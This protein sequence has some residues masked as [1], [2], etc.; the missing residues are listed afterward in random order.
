MALPA[1]R[2]GAARPAKLILRPGEGLAISIGRCRPLPAPRILGRSLLEAG[3]QAFPQG[4]AEHRKMSRRFFCLAIVLAAS[5]IV[6]TQVACAD[7]ALD[8]EQ[9]K[10][11]LHTATIEEDGFICKTVRMVNKGSLPADLFQST[12][13]WARKKPRRKFQYFKHAL[14]LRAAE[15]GIDLTKCQRST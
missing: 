3:G 9:I 1:R 11:V 8:P 6:W 10:A 13:Q 12:L 4:Q 7:G 2:M 15:I 14:V 5:M